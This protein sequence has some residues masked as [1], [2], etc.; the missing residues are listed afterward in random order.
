MKRTSSLKLCIKLPCWTHIHL[1]KALLT[2]A[3]AM[4]WNA[5][6]ICTTRTILLRWIYFTLIPKHH[7]HMAERATMQSVQH[8][9]WVRLIFIDLKRAKHGQSAVLDGTLWKT[10]SLGTLVFISPISRNPLETYSRSGLKR[11]VSSSVLMCWMS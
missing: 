8:V 5:M 2:L 4:C 11:T 3:A 9:I 6:L 10:Y 1:N 7:D